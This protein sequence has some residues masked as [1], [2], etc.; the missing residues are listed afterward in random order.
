MLNLKSKLISKRKSKS[1][2][3]IIKAK[4]KGR[5]LK[6]G[7][8]LKKIKAI[9]TIPKVKQPRKTKKSCQCKDEEEKVM[10]KPIK[11]GVVRP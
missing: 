4:G 7:L 9:K 3:K 2:D 11:K 8:E 1:V 5:K 10:E 6:N